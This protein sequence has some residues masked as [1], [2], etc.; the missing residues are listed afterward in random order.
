M[1]TQLTR[2]PCWHHRGLALLVPQPLLQDGYSLV[3]VNLPPLPTSPVIQPRS[4]SPDAVPTLPRLLTS[5]PGSSL[6]SPSEL[7]EQ[8][9]NPNP[10]LCQLMAWHVPPACSLTTVFW[11]HW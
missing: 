2:V 11:S 10:L 6:D 5:P 8:G 1:A 4:S 3:D 9:R 7:G